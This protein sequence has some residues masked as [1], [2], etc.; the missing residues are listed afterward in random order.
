MPGRRLRKVDCTDDSTTGGVAVVM[1]ISRGHEGG[2][3]LVSGAPGV[4][5]ASA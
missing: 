1:A 3:E 5:G 2:K 4:G